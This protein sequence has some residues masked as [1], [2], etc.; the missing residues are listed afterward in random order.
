M[1][2]IHDPVDRRTFFGLLAIGL[3]SVVAGCA[4][5]A[6]NQPPQTPAAAPPHNWDTPV[7]PAPEGGPTRVLSH[8]PPGTDK[9]ALTVDDGYNDMVVTGYVD[10]AVRTGIHLTFGPNGTY[11]HA[12]APHADQLR[13]LVERR[14][15]QIINHTFSHLD[16][17]RMTDAQIRAELE[18]NEDWVTRTFRTS[19]KPYYRPPFGFHN[20]H[21]DGVANEIGYRNTVLWNG[22]Y[23]DSE[24]IT[25]AY[26]MTQARKYLRPGTIMLGHANHPA[27][28]GLFDQITELI[29][30]RNLTPATLNELLAT[31]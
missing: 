18:R 25:P 5:P 31:P 13:P 29:R 6:G 12:W 22:T 23:G 4:N 15:V 21:I 10:F 19:T 27:I 30:Q 2:G 3:A 1:G 24:P 16:L 28:L 20:E 8:G 9:I 11:A 7:P 17:R 26:L 14:Q